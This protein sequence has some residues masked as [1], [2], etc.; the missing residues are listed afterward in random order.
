MTFDFLGWGASDKPTGYPYTATNQ[1]GD[2]DAVIQHL[3]LGSVV[4]VAHDASGP[5]RSTG[6][7]TTPSEW[8]PWCCSTPTTPA[9]PG[10]ARQGDPAV[11]YPA[12]PLGRPPDLAGLQRPAV[13]AHLPLA[14]G[15][16]LPRPGHARGVPAAAVPPVPAA[17]PS[18]HEAF[19]GLNRDLL[20]T[21]AAGQPRCRGSA[22]SPAQS[23]SSSAPPTPTSTPGSPGASAL[24]DLGAV[25]APGA[26][27]YVQLDEPQV[28]RLILT[29]PQ[30]IARRSA[31]SLHPPASTFTPD[32]PWSRS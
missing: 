11:L 14:G 22:S 16:L 3:Q 18:T 32:R 1:I 21:V 26:R 27:H 9:C 24:S 20:P 5:R 30:R 10:C 31:G 25:P 15:P 6:P 4:L 29:I 12:G 2:L 7:W 23:G 8:R 17:S 19:F 13:P 28:A